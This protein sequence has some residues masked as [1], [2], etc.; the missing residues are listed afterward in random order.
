[1]SGRRH[2]T[3]VAVLGA[4]VVLLPLRSE[5]FLTSANLFGMTRHL[6]EVGIVACGMTLVVVTGG[7][8][9]SV[10]SLLALSGVVLGYAWRDWGLALPAA[11]A[12]A[13]LVAG[14]GG[15]LNGLLVARAGFAPL[16]ATLGTMA[17]YRGLALRIS[18]ARPVS[19]FPPGFAQ[20]G[21]GHLGPVPVQTLL[22]GAVAAAVGWLLHRAPVGL[23]LRAIG[24][25]YIERVWNLDALSGITLLSFPIEELL[26]AVAFGTY[27]SGWYE[28]FTWSRSV[29]DARRVTK[30]ER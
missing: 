21:Q 30:A 10:G 5:H 4:L 3:L 8:D 18:E 17:L 7:I 1:V 24:D 12:L 16:V 2:L 29:P 28:H 6:A 27:W 26:W 14:A 9:L 13:L 19:G 11:A 23:L 25:N 15:A 22:W 20:L